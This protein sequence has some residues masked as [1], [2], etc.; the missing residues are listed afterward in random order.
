[1]HFVA[2]VGANDVDQVFAD[3]VHVALD[4]CQ[5]QLALGCA[6][7]GLFHVRLKVSNRGLHC[8]RA[9]QHERQLH[10]ARAE[11]FADLAHAIE[12]NLVDD[13]ERSDSF[14]HCSIE[15]IGETVS[16]A[17]DDALAQNLLHCPSRAVFAH[18]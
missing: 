18:G 2:V 12:K 17:V 14:G 9:L 15:V 7:A 11:Q 10:L 6:L 5:N 1:M 3:V 8:F 13:V 4:C 16:I